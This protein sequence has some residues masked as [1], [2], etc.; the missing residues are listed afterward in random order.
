MKNIKKIWLLFLI[1]CSEML[2]AQHQ[3]DLGYHNI[4]LGQDYLATIAYGSCRDTSG[5]LWIATEKG[6]LR[7]DGYQTRV[8]VHNPADPASLSSN[9]V[10]AVYV[11]KQGTLWVGTKPKGLNKYVDGKFKH[12]F[13]LKDMPE[14]TGNTWIRD[15]AEDENGNFWI[16]M[17]GAGLALFDR[18]TERYKLF[19]KDSTDDRAIPGNSIT[20]LLYTSNKQLYVGT[21]QGLCRLDDP[22][23]GTFTT[24][25]YKNHKPCKK[26]LSLTEDAEGGIWAG[27]WHEGLCK[28]DASSLSC[29]MDDHFS[30]DYAVV[31]LEADQNKLI[32]GTWGDGIVLY[33][34][35]I[36]KSYKNIKQKNKETGLESTQIRHIFEDKH[37]IFWISTNKGI[38]KLDKYK[39]KF[40]GNMYLTIESEFDE[41]SEVKGFF[42]NEKSE[43]FILT[44]HGIKPFMPGRGIVNDPLI[45]NINAVIGNSMVN[46]MAEENNNYFIGTREKGLFIFDK[47]GRFI[48]RIYGDAFSQDGKNY[49]AHIS[50]LLTDTAKIYILTNSLWEMDLQT[51]QL[52]LLH[53][54][55]NQYGTCMAKGPDGYIWIGAWQIGATKFNPE[56]GEAVNYLNQIN[57]GTIN[58][59]YLDSQ[60]NF[61]IGTRK[62]LNIYMPQENKFNF[63]Q[64]DNKIKDVAVRSVLKHNGNLWLSTEFGIAFKP[65]E[66]ENFILYDKSNGLPGIDF[67][68]SSALKASKGELFFGTGEGILHFYPDHLNKKKT[69]EY[70]F[71]DGVYLNCQEKINPSKK[72]NYKIFAGEPLCIKTIFTDL[73]HPDKN[74]YYYRLSGSDTMWVNNGSNRI[75][76]FDELPK[77]KHSISIKAAN[78]DMA[79][80]KNRVIV[81]LQVIGKWRGYWWIML[82][83]VPFLVV[84]FLMYRGN[85]KR[86]QP[87]YAKSTLKKE[88]M[89][90]YLK[91]LQDY[92]DKEK[93]FTKG[94][95]YL[96]DVAE[97]L[98]INQNYLSQSI[99]ELTK[100]NFYDY[101]NEYRVA[102]AKKLLTDPESN[103][104]NL[105]GIGYESGFNS[106]TSFYTIFKKHTG[107]T[108]TEYRKSFQ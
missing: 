49:P 30:A 57:D 21:F 72:G 105:L 62:G 23:S 84:G 102:E 27:T 3:I 88:D 93:P 9:H 34:Y 75:M 100:K 87:K 45:Q 73:S 54:L 55:N 19:T 61:W 17:D 32:M 107:Q 92:M 18:E 11:D 43:I 10:S 14:G 33:D 26:I 29:I 78:Q 25:S 94:E 71:N 98:E 82:V 44:E 90:K 40:T 89:E 91:Q 60:N 7:Y 28:V 48:R 99:N 67:V 15:F 50:A 39:K 85:I 46:C 96:K 83:V 24:F 22:E 1:C 6:L 16:A 56:T 68:Y 52:K 66:N 5:Y 76:L 13:R 31:G 74:N 79:W 103:K 51:F 12:Y 42:E 95:V 101:V 63:V 37:N 47:A 104:M 36:G 108:P 4:N 80:S 41:K 20:C 64:V 70:I 58:C 2:S 59:M 38:A 53:V 35:K 106:K 69:T 81:D 65:F 97:K 8:F 86:K 77:G